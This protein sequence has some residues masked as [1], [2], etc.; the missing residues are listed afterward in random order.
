MGQRYGEEFKREAVRLALTSNP[1][2]NASRP[3]Q[4]KSAKSKRS[5]PDKYHAA[6]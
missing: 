6:S 3:C 1:A 2:K 4:T 5:K